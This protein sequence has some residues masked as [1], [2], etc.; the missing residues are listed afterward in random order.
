M[1]FLTGFDPSAVDEQ[2]LVKCLPQNLEY[3][4]LL[5]DLYREA[6]PS[7][8]FWDEEL[9]TPT[10]VAWLTHINTYAGIPRLKRLCLAFVEDDAWDEEDWDDMEFMTIRWKIRE[11]GRQMGIEITTR[12]DIMFPVTGWEDVI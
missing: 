2:A 10:I 3:L 12:P 11:L 9:F 7:A 4:T 6:D 5:E 8:I 1:A